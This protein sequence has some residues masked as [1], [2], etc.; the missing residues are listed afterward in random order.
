VDLRA[1][2]TMK[3][4]YQLKETK[5]FLSPV[6]EG[7]SSQLEKKVLNRLIM[8]IQISE[9]LKLFTIP[10]KVRMSVHY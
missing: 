4:K 10:M 2:V 6:G 9:F 8:K 3:L 1:I 7:G 5:I